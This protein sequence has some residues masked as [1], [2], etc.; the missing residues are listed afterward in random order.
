M[1]CAETVVHPA[2]RAVCR[3]SSS[4]SVSGRHS[5]AD[6]L[7]PSAYYAEA[8]VAICACGLPAAAQSGVWFA[9]SRDALVWR[10]VARALKP[11]KMSGAFS[12]NS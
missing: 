4:A 9:E 11:R 6:G 8:D 2:A 3:A 1:R 5:S 7:C 10:P 12:V